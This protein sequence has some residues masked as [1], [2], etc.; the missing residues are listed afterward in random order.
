M[1]GTLGLSSPW[2]R[3]AIPT[4]EERRAIEAR[5]PDG[6]TI[7]VFC[8]SDRSAYGIRVIEQGL[9]P[10]YNRVV[11]GGAEDRHWFRNVRQGIDQAITWA[12]GRVSA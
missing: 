1:S 11:W 6:Y 9:L 8:N 4:Y 7:G 12:E 5:I 10:Q 3:Q 2:A